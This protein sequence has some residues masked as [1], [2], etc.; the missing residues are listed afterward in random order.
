MV[1]VDLLTENHS[2]GV[3]YCRG[4]PIRCGKWSYLHLRQQLSGSLLRHLRGI[5]N[6]RQRSSQVFAGRN[7][8]S[9]WTSY[10]PCVGGELGRDTPRL[11]GG[12]HHPDTFH[13]LQVGPPHTGEE[14]TDPQD[15][16]DRRAEREEEAEGSSEGREAGRGGTAG[17][18]ATGAINKQF[19]LHQGE[20]RGDES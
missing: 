1:R 10:V 8:A 11:T 14:L 16:G 12:N 20:G 7:I 15:A 4:N 2:L 19:K 9:C 17:T 18:A 3:A 5:G 13:L 6:G